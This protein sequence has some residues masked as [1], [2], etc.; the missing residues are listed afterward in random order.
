[1]RVVVYLY[2]NIPSDVIVSTIDVSRQEVT[3]QTYLVFSLA[4]SYLATDIVTEIIRIIFTKHLHY[5]SLYSS[6]FKAQGAV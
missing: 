1:M 6:M 4:R 2:C 3:E 5:F